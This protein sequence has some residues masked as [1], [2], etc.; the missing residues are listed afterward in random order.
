ME[1]ER[2]DQNSKFRRVRSE[3]TKNGLRNENQ[4]TR[5]LLI[6]KGVL[7]GFGLLVKDFAL[8]GLM[9]GDANNEMD[10]SKVAGQGASISAQRAESGS[11]GLP[12]DSEPSDRCDPSASSTKGVDSVGIPTFSTSP[13]LWTA[14]VIF[15]DYLQIFYMN[16]CLYVRSIF[17]N[18][19]MAMIIRSMME[20]VGNDPNGI[21]LKSKKM[22]SKF[23][24]DVLQ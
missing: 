14:G 11:C 17:G 10:L 15:L 12:L 8:S 3:K 21:P 20:Q 6:A 24:S 4:L 5:L 1:G 7:P 23:S 22:H 18:Q 13:L 16:K 2:K 19:V 9:T